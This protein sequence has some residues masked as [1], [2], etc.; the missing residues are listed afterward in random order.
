MKTTVAE[1]KNS[2]ESFNSR[3]DKAGE[4]ISE[5]KDSNK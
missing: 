2:I 4:K 1:L 3:L 5:H